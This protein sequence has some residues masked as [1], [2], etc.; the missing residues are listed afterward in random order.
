[1]ADEKTKVILGRVLRYIENNSNWQISLPERYRLKNFDLPDLTSASAALKLL[2]QVKPCLQ[3]AIPLLEPPP[4]Y[5]GRL[6]KR[7]EAI[8][9]GKIGS[10]T[11]I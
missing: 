8:A 4:L 2:G 5:L 10:F 9:A 7:L 3:P 1:M 11:P 6:K